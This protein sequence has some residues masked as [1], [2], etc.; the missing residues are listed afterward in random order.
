MH[1]W[2]RCRGRASPGRLR[3]RRGDCREANRISPVISLYALVKV[4]FRT[5]N[6]HDTMPSSMLWPALGHQG[7][8]EMSYAVIHQYKGASKEQYEA[9]LAAVHPGGG[10]LPPG[11]LHHFAGPSAAGWIIVAIHDSRPSWETFRDSTLM[12]PS[13][14]S[15]TC[16]G[17]GRMIHPCS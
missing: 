7:G 9:T 12:P 3:H 1:G 16:C 11:Q 14:A 4:I 2:L 15:L 5:Q 8:P 13:T 10:T 6:R 17:P